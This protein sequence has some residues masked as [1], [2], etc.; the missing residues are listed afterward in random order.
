MGRDGV[1]LVDDRQDAQAEQT[2][3]GTL[4]VAAV[5]RIL[6]I[7]RGEENLS[8]DDVVAVEAFLVAIDEHVLANG[9]SGLLGGEVGRTGIQ[10]Q[11]GHA[12]RDG[13]G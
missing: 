11:V 8:G 12:G 5:R 3:H 1:I 10:F 9:G 4:G 6:E 13:S 7:S 2:L